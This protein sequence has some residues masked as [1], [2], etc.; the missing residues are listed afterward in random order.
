MTTILAPRSLCHRVHGYGVTAQFYNFH[1]LYIC[2]ETYFNL[3]RTNKIYV[4]LF[5]VLCLV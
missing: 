4:Q 2:T 5:S 1:Y 3:C